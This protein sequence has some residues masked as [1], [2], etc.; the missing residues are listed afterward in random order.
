M[1]KLDVKLVW[2][3]DAK[4]TDIN[5]GVIKALIRST[6]LVQANAKVLVPVDKGILKGSIVKSV[7]NNK[8]EGR[9]ST[10]LEY[11]P[12]VELGLKSNPNYPRQPYMR[13]ALFDNKDKIESIFI[14]EGEKAVDN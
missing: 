5:I 3:G 11:A 10:N 13:P 2:D 1:A 12:Y 4:K 9:V 8:L 7:E 6:N 14:K